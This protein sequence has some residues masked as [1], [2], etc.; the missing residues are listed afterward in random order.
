VLGVRLLYCIRQKLERAM[1]IEPTAVAWEAE[2]FLNAIN[3]HST[4]AGRHRKPF[5][6][7]SLFRRGRRRHAR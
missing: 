2:Y 1:G 4:A 3:A 6:S 7:P 5:D